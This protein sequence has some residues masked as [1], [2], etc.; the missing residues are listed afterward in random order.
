[1]KTPEPNPSTLITHYVV[2]DLEATTDSGKKEACAVPRT[3]METLEFGAVLVSAD[4]LQPLETFQS[5]VQPVRHPILTRFCTE[6]TGIRQEMIE[7]AP[8]FPVAMEALRKAMFEGRPGVAWA[9]W[10]QFDDNQLRQ[11]HDFHGM[12]YEMPPHL[13]L[14]K[15]FQEVQARDRPCGMAHA[16]RLCELQLEG[17]HHRALDDAQNIAKLLPWILG[18]NRIRRP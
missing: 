7:G 8:P 12:P 11:D 16:L 1:M 4:A 3:E 9:S 15:R 14:K 13:N 10:G 5:F 17:A 6:L 18:T 2:I